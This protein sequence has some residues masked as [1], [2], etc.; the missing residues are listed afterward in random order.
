MRLDQLLTDIIRRQ[1][2]TDRRLDGMVKQGA[3]AEVDPKNGTVRLHLGGSDGD[4]FLSPHIPYAQMAGGLKV[5]SPPTVGQQMTILSGSG[6]FR[7][8]L[9]L[10]MTWS[11]NNRAPS[12]KGDENVITFGNFRAELRG[13]ELLVTI[14]GFSLSLKSSGATFS[15]DGVTHEITG[16]GVATD[17]GEISHDGKNIGSDHI[18]GGVESG[19]STTSG[20]LG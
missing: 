19:G 5:H 2:E 18:H 7:Q 20:P 9:A 12:E 14:G 6:D 17:G 10:P 1:S 11:D 3:V 16:A 4:D 15:V 13:D 8:G